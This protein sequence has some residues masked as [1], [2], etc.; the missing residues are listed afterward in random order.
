MER[1]RF[2]LENQDKDW[3]LWAKWDLYNDLKDS[4]GHGRDLSATTPG[5]LNFNGSYVE[6]TAG[7]AFMN[8]QITETKERI[9]LLNNLK[10]EAEFYQKAVGLRPMFDLFSQWNKVGILMNNENNPSYYYFMSYTR[11]L[12]L[13]N[14]WVKLVV[15]FHEISG[16]QHVMKLTIYDSSGSQYYTVGGKRSL[17]TTT[18]GSFMVI[19]GSDAYYP[20]RFF[21]GYIRNVKIYKKLRY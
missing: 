5:Y 13:L 16:T 18:T 3:D 17:Y 12:A 2:I 4:S 8:Y 19:G 7:H 21:Y 10:F 11:T 20:G 6:Q 1:R 9:D 15:E 14:Q